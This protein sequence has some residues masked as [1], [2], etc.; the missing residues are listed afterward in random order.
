MAVKGWHTITLP[1][2]LLNEVEQIVNNNAMGYSSKSE[3]I[4]EAIRQ[5][6]LELKEAELLDK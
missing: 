1:D 3:F 6:I 4:R 5:R 2:S